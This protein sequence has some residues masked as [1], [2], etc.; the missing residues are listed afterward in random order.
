MQS[1]ATITYDLAVTNTGSVDL[2]VVI[3]DIL[4]AMVTSPGPVTWGPIVIQPGDV[5]TAQITG[6]VID[7]IGTLTNVLVAR[8]DDGTTTVITATSQAIFTPFSAALQVNRFDDVYRVPLA[9]QCRVPTSTDCSLR[10][11][12]GLANLSRPTHITILLPTGTYTLT[13]PETSGLDP[14]A[15]GDLNI[16]G[17]VTILGGGQSSLL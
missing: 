2:H 9:N 13:L 4:P 12:I 16:E 7:Y 14:N 15:G 8:A 6:T 5:F 1:G 10:E 17:N 11:A 3:T